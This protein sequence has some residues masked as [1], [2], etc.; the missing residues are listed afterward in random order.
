MFRKALLTLTGVIADISTQCSTEG[1]LISSAMRQF[2]RELA[3]RPFVSVDSRDF[4]SH[5]S[6]MDLCHLW[7]TLPL[8]VTRYWLKNC[9]YYLENLTA[10]GDYVH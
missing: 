9:Q 1:V 7:Y 4:G 8:T 2:Q 5:V 10:K 6:N 3:S